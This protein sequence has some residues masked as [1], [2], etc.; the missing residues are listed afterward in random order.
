MCITGSLHCTTEIDRTLQ[1]NYNKKTIYKKK[2]KKKD[3][4]LPGKHNKIESYDSIY[5]IS[6]I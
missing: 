3:L 1:I 2:E 4:P 5:C 6:M